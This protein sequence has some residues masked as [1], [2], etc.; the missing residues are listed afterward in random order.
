MILPQDTFA[1]L[2]ETISS[3]GK[4]LAGIDFLRLPHVLIEDDKVGQHLPTRSPAI[5]FLV[6]ELR[7]LLYIGKAKD[8]RSRW[9]FTGI[10]FNNPRP[11]TEGE[12]KYHELSVYFARNSVHHCLGR[13]LEL[14]GVTIHYWKLPKKYL[15]IVELLLLAELK[16]PWNTHDVGYEPQT[17]RGLLIISLE[18]RGFAVETRYSPHNEYD[19]KC[20]VQLTRDGLTRKYTGQGFVGVLQQAVA[21]VERDFP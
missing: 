17:E 5:Y 4:D 19:K 14:G 1:K 6:H 18:E 13:A 10:E 12:D 21:A 7:E 8:L 9:L 11:L 2:D 3:L 20:L 15:S 16:P